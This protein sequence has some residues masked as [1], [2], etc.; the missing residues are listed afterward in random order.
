MLTNE[1][2]KLAPKPWKDLK[3]RAL[4]ILFKINLK[5][6]SSND[7]RSPEHAYRAYQTSSMLRASNSENPSYLQTGIYI[8][9]A[10]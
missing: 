7:T 10:F 1:A 9:I 4:T 8:Y 2:S 6:N 5:H 3:H